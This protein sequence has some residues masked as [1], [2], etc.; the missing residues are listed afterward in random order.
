MSWKECQE[1]KRRLLKLYNQ[2]KT[3]YGKGVWYDED[4]N[5]YYRY[6][7]SNRP[8]SRARYFKNYSNRLI[9]RR[10][11]NDS[12]TGQTLKKEFD[13]WWEIL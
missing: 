6:Y 3:Y 11:L 13:L 2:T 8:Y 12:V 1:R 4:T 10:K 5:R 9:R 7:L